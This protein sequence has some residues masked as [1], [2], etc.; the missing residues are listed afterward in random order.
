MQKYVMI[1]TISTFEITYMIPMQ[2]G[3]SV[4]QHLDYITCNEAEEMSQVH[5][6]ETI[7]TNSTQ[8]LTQKQALERFDAENAYLSEW[9]QE[10]KLIMIHNSISKEEAA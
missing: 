3:Q 9:A 7:L 10:Q 6:D 5:L 4:E 8:V 1:K 2:A